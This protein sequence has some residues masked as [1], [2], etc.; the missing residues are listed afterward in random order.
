MT[1]FSTRIKVL[2]EDR[3]WSQEHLSETS[4]LSIKTIQRVESGKN[5]SLESQQA[6]AQAFDLNVREL[7]ENPENH[8]VVVPP[9]EYVFEIYYQGE[10]I[11]Q[12]IYTSPV[13]PPLPGEQI[14][15]VFQNSNYSKEYGNWWIVKKRRHLKFNESVNIETLMLTCVPDTNQGREYEL[16]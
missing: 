15:V 13:I 9:R 7:R 4:G 5:V 11:E 8:K 16:Y 3:G 2:R 12:Q 1:A 10:C 6:L 14:Y